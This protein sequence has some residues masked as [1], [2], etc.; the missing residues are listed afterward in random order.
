VAVTS[1]IKWGDGAPDPEVD[2]AVDGVYY[3]GQSSAGITHY[4]QCSAFAASEF[5]AGDVI[6]IHV[7]RQGT[8]AGEINYGI[9]DGVDF[10]DGKTV[11]ME[12]Y[13]V[14]A[15]NNR[16]VFRQPM[17]EEFVD[18]F[19]YASLN[20]SSATGNAYAFITSAQHIH[21]VYVYAATNPVMYVSRLQ[22]DGS[23][24]EYHQPSDDN[25]DFPSVVRFTANWYAEFN[26]WAPQLTEIIF[27]AAPF[28]N[29]GAAA[30]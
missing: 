27:C 4:I 24:I 25:V 12:I 10:L 23:H 9:T 18:A 1:P 8:G 3:P 26:Q 16:L 11:T 21:P 30:Y 17:T 13:E 19:S 6:S 14:D 22:P 28:A 2:A 15:V 7:K 29:T 20:G 5:V